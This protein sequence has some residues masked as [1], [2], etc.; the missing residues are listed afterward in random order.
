[1][2]RV[3]N[4]IK[5]MLRSVYNLYMFNLQKDIFKANR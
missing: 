5:S 3:Q 1:M 4:C 2:L